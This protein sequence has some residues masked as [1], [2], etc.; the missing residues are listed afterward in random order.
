MKIKGKTMTELLTNLIFGIKHN[1]EGH[2]E[3]LESE[4]VKNIFRIN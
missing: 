3:L 1:L 4:D 2:F